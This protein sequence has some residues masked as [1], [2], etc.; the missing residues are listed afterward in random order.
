MITNN[1]INSI[2]K[3]VVSK[4]HPELVKSHHV[5]IARPKKASEKTGSVVY[6]WNLHV[7]GKP[8]KKQ[9]PYLLLGIMEL[10]NKHW[11]I[12]YVFDVP[13]EA[14]YKAKN[15]YL[16]ESVRR[17]GSW[18]DKYERFVKGLNLVPSDQL[19]YERLLRSNRKRKQKVDF[20]QTPDGS[21]YPI[22]VLRKP[23]G[24][25]GYV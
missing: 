9:M 25:E 20:S 6:Q 8:R 10:E 23:K 24:N 12:R 17:R 3:K 16:C 19:E 4:F 2:Y 15:I 11:T 1:E 22:A 21:I 13:Y 18:I 7:H 14:V 5:L